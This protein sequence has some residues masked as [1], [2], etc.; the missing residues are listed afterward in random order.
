M[1]DP[2]LM[3]QRR[4]IMPRSR[5]SSDIARMFAAAVIAIL[6]TLVFVGLA[7]T[8]A[9]PA[10]VASSQWTER[11]VS[12]SSS[13]Q[14]YWVNSTANADY[15]CLQLLVTPGGEFLNG[16]FNH[17]PGTA[18]INFWLTQGLA[19]AENPSSCPPGWTWTSPDGTGQIYWT[20]SGSV[21]LR[22]LN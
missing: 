6:A 11:T 16:T 8:G 7:A 21:V 13:L 9:L 10:T 3:T 15:F 14:C 18:V 12:A 17:W 1:S 4:G 2:L 5:A 20:L 19:C 22:A